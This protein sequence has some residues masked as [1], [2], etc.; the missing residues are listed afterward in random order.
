MRYNSSSQG[1]FRM[2]E[3]TGEVREIMAGQRTIRTIIRASVLIGP[4][5]DIISARIAPLA[6]IVTG[7]DEQYALSMD[8]APTDVK[9]FLEVIS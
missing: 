4:E 7:P 2:I 5:N 8:D 1:P 6:Q 3:V 9:A